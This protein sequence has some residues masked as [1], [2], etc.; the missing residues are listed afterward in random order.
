MKRKALTIHDIAKKLNIAASTVSRA[1]NNNPNISRTTIEKVNAYAIEIGY[2]PNWI[3]SN[4][5]KRKTNSIGIVVPQ[6]NRNFFSCFIS[7]VEEIA[8]KKNYNVIISQSNNMLE[9]EKKIVYSLFSNQ[10][11][12]LIVSLSMQTN[13]FSHF[14]LFQENNIPL[15]FFDRV[16]TSLNTDRIIVDDF[17]AGYRA[18][19]H[20]IDQGYKKIAHI[21]GPTV[22]EIYSLR[23]D[24]YLKA[25]KDNN[26]PVKKEYILN[27]HLLRED[28]ENSMKQ[29][30]G[31]KIPPDAIFCGNDTSALGLMMYLKKMG[32]IIPENIGIVGFSDEPFSELITPTL[33][34]LRQ[35]AFEMGEKAAGLLIERI[36]KNENPS[37][38]KTIVMPTKLIIR[39]S[40]SAKR[41]K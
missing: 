16:A 31:L 9:K 38:F 24:G 26:L 7:G 11:D 22:L 2:R 33:S 15:V 30:L 25:L 19:K 23:K 37:D 32:I 12:G 17:E 8:F 3:A 13:E 27:S 21:A 4:L 40:S 41:N 6:I 34:T 14:K 29:F 1:L 10:V 5:R 36:E 28:G 39:E 35:P 18:T 20:L